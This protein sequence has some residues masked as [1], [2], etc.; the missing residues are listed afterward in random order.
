MRRQACYLL[1]ISL[2]FKE[3]RS[4]PWR[5]NSMQIGPSSE[6]WTI[7]HLMIRMHH[8]YELRIRLFTAV[9]ASSRPCIS[10]SLSETDYARSRQIK[11]AT[12]G[13]AGLHFLFVQQVGRSRRHALYCIHVAMCVWISRDGP[14]GK[15][16]S[17]LLRAKAGMVILICENVACRLLV[18]RYMHSDVPTKAASERHVFHIFLEQSICFPCCCGRVS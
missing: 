10:L 4:F 18:A 9:L 2:P 11:Q 7:R 15:W 8:E 1:Y 12:D 5:I 3:K 17:F 14:R 6:C 16:I 13:R